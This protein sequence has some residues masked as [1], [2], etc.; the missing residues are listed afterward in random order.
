MMQVNQ[1]SI[2]HLFIRFLCYSFPLVSLFSVFLSFLFHSVIPIS[3]FRLSCPSPFLPLPMVLSDS[4]PVKAQYHLLHSIS[5]P[6]CDTCQVWVCLIT[7]S[8]SN[9]F[10]ANEVPSRRPSWSDP[11]SHL[12]GNRQTSPLHP[13]QAIDSSAFQ[14]RVS[15][16][17][18]ASP[19]SDGLSPCKNYLT[20]SVVQT[21]S[22]QGAFGS[23]A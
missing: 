16:F 1:S 15:L 5:S 21:P 8:H 17:E 2:S 20:N 6:L 22:W 9:F 23:D 14:L 3:V 4:P 13:W 18:S 7:P 11:M 10:V 12:H 19:L